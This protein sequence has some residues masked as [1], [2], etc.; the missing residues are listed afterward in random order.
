MGLSYL[1]VLPDASGVNLNIVISRIYDSYLQSWF[2]DLDTYS[3]LDCYRSFKQCFIY[4]KYLTFIENKNHRIALTRFRCSSHK[5]LIEVGRHRNLE[6]DERKC[7]FCKCNTIENEYHFLLVCPLY[8]DLRMLYLPKYY[9]TWPNTFKFK[10][11][12]ESQSKK[13]IVNLGKFVYLANCK[14]DI[15]NTS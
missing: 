3:K 9:Y 14:R 11:L 15:L 5:L 7:T 2:A 6:R 4:E 10:G 13:K 1:N 12:M 8:R